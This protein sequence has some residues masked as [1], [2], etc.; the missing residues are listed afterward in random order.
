MVMLKIFD[1]S[2]MNY[3][4]NLIDDN[5]INDFTII[6][7]ESNKYKVNKGIISNFSSVF[8][9]M[10]KGNFK[11]SL[12][13]VLIIEDFSTK[14]ISSAIYYFYNN[15]INGNLE[16]K[17]YFDLLIFADKY[18]IKGLFII[19]EFHLMRQICQKDIKIFMKYL[20]FV[21]SQKLKT[22]VSQFCFYHNCNLCS[23][24]ILPKPI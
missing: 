7:G 18:D 2:Y 22:I 13:N 17:E 21:D 24:H 4:K 20:N 9:V 5:L 12:S 11:E 8:K 10:I 16:I 3:E 14:I 6:D 15:I 1:S 19:L 23:P